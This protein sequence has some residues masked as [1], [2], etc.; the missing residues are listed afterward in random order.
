MK[1]PEVYLLAPDKNVLSQFIVIKTK[2]N[3]VVVIDGGHELYEPCLAPAIRAIL[4]LSDGDY[5]E[6]D[7]WFL[8][9]PHNDHY[10]EA[11]KL[12]STMQSGA[13]FKVKNFYFD[14]PDLYNC[15]FSPSDYSIESY[16]ALKSAFCNYATKTGEKDPEN[17]FDSLNGKI[18]NQSSVK[19]GL[20]I[21][22]DGVDFDI[23]QT[24][25]NEDEQVNSCS[26]VIRARFLVDGIEKKILFLNDVSKNSGNRLLKRYG[27]E[28]KSDAVQISHHGQAGADKNVYDA[29][30]A[31]FRLWP[32][33]N[34][35]W[36]DEKTFLIGETRSWFNI[37][38][39]GSD[40]DLVSCAY[41][42][43]PQDRTKADDWKKCIAQMK[44]S[45]D[46]L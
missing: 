10:G 42:D 29:I 30:N 40:Y 4:G 36:T 41:K 11:T 9:H 12:L 15:T 28:L 1:N 23:L 24:R 33:T 21:T 17:Y 13:E 16:N 3:K 31:K 34:W 39:C 32:T 20:T 38:A 7:G 8:S 19:K 37:T 35:V 25:S 22:I 2:N 5:F 6:I 44:L 14:Y 26:M 18:I 46:K 43:Y 27:S 45:V